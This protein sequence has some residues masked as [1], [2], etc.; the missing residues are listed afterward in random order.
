[1]RSDNAVAMEA[2]KM[3][4]GQEQANRRDWDNR[5]KSLPK[6]SIAS[7]RDPLPL[8]AATPVASITGTMTDP[9]FSSA[10]R[11]RERGNG[12]FKMFSRKRSSN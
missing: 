8:I 1:M 3:E 4:Q 6:A 5:H 2:L 11:K 9:Y 7:V 10:A 12:F